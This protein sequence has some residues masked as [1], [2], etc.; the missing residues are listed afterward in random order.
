MPMCCDPCG[1]FVKYN[2][3]VF[4]VSS[5]IFICVKIC[6]LVVCSFYYDQY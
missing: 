2:K 3:F 1:M 5:L 4:F 6:N